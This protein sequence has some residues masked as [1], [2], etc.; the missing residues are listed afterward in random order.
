MFTNS[1]LLSPT[2]S[3]FFRPKISNSWSEGQIQAYHLFFLIFFFF[4][5]R[6]WPNDFWGTGVICFK[7]FQWVYKSWSWYLI[8]VTST[9]RNLRQED[10]DEFE[11]SLE[12][13]VLG[14]PVLTYTV[15]PYLQKQG[16]VK[17]KHNFVTHKIRWNQILRS[18][19]TIFN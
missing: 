14:Y 13:I 2:F 9:V 5:F 15:R 12:C 1:S 6:P 8:P 18:I 4:L 7:H 17:S 10:Y 3:L 11:V 16:S 19:N